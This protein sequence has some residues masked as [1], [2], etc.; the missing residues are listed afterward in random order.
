MRSTE[1]SA[2]DLY[3]T[4]TNASK[5]YPGASAHQDGT[6]SGTGTVYLIHLDEPYKHARHYLGWTSDLD[7]RL[8]A[9]Q[10]GRGARLMEVVKSAGITWRL[11]RTWPGSRDRERAIKNRHEAPRLCPECSPVPRPVTAGRSAGQAGPGRR[12][13]AVPAAQ[14]AHELAPRLPAIDLISD[15]WQAQSPGPDLRDAEIEAD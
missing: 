1:P 9:H 3:G 4:H 10:E 6:V 5:G 15:P 2:A 11:A 12:A 13:A 8:E 14:P 7:A